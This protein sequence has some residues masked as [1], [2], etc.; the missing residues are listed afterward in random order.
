MNHGKAQMFVVVQQRLVAQPEEKFLAIMGVEDTGQG[1]LFA[2]GQG[3]GGGGQELEVVIAED[4]DGSG[5][6]AAYEAQQG[7][8]VG[9]SVDQIA[10]KPEAILGGVEIDVVQQAQQIVETAL[11][12][13]NGI[14]RADLVHRRSLDPGR[15]S[16]PD[17]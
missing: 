15:F 9:P 16:R 10:G 7:Q 1:I 12:I 6:Q 3:A 4:A 11:D 13:A 5:T 8:G 14:S 2:E 17:G